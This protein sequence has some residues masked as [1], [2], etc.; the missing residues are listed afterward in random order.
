MPRRRNL[1]L[2]ASQVQAA[3]E[4][5]TLEGKIERLKQRMPKAWYKEI[6]ATSFE[7]RD[8]ATF[9]CKV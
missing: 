3:E 5:Q 2:N 9:S 7:L 8:S 6:I 1:L 4:D